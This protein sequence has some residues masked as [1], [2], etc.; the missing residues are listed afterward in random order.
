MYLCQKGDL[1]S[2]L[3]N[4]FQNIPAKSIRKEP[5]SNTGNG[6]EHFFFIFAGEQ[7]EREAQAQH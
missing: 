1:S 5:S 3:A 4:N 6:E 2:V 7:D